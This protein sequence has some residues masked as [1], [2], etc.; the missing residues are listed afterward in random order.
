MTPLIVMYCLECEWDGPARDR[1]QIELEVLTLE[2]ELITGHDIASVWLQQ[3]RDRQ[4]QVASSFWNRNEDA[5]LGDVL[6]SEP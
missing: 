5:S 2:H 4:L 1:P 3:N 6:N